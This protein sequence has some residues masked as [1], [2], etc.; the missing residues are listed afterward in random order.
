MPEG[1]DEFLRLGSGQFAGDQLADRANLR[2]QFLRACTEGE[3]TSA[4][5]LSFSQN[6]G[7]QAMTNCRERQFLDNACQPTKV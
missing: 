6:P 1:S 7:D 4:F 5:T 3:A 2:S